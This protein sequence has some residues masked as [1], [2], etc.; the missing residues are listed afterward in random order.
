[1]ANGRSVAVERWC[2]PWPSR[3]SF[4]SATLRLAYVYHATLARHR[5]QQNKKKKQTLVTV[6]SANR[7]HMNAE[8]TLLRQRR[9]V[10]PVKCNILGTWKV[11][12]N[13]LPELKAMEMGKQ[14]NRICMHKILIQIT[15]TDFLKYEDLLTAYTAWTNELKKE[16][17]QLLREKRLTYRAHAMC[18]MSETTQRVMEG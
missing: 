4:S 10:N 5:T 9:N 14:G 18:S 15:N 13:V 17:Y 2:T 8:N 3:I 6:T 12:E 1:M 11:F 7:K 16:R